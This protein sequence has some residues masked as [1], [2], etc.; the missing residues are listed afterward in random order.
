MPNATV[1]Y[2]FLP[3]TWFP[4]LELHVAAQ[5]STP[6]DIGSCLPSCFMIFRFFVFVFF[7]FL[8]FFK[9]FHFF[10]VLTLFS[11]AGLGARDV[12]CG[13]PSAGQKQ[14]QREASR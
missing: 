4:T 11:C 7:S 9:F 14:R 5:E 12:H 8:V 2:G 1:N 6:L 3:Q 13:E 10:F